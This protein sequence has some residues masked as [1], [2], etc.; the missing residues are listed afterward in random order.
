MRSKVQRRSG[1]LNK[2]TGYFIHPQSRCESSTI[3]SGTRIWG[4]T[5]IMK[6]VVIGANCNICDFV[7]I[8]DGV[9]IG[10]NVTIKSGVYLWEGL[11]IEDD[12]FIGP[13]VTFANDLYPRSGMHPDKYLETIV[14]RGSSIGSNATI[15]PGVVIGEGSMVGAGAVVTRNVENNSVVVGNP[16]KK[17]AHKG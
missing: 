13:N 3:G 12:V 8:E 11:T 17:I 9:E 15:L 4:F 14:K 10:S 16:A 7:F 6:N 2:E 5:R 1:I